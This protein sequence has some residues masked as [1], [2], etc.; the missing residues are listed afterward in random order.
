MFLSC[1]GGGD[2]IVTNAHLGDLPSIAK[3]YVD[4]LEAKEQELK[5]N[6]NLEKAFTIAKEGE[7]LEEE[8]EKTIEEHLA[9]NPIV[10]IPFEMVGDYPFTINDISVKN[11]SDSRI[12]FNIKAVITEDVGK[13]LFVYIRA[14]DK[15]GNQLTKKNGVMMEKAA[16]RSFKAN[17]EVDF[18]GSLDG[19]ADLVNFD[20]LVLISKES[21]NTLK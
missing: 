21:Y 14:L 20:K 11:S 18:V 17:E 12:N 19:P 5:V 16:R 8:A 6:T 2:S 3:N 4:K 1:G 7:L 15:E 13:N 10:N 9:N